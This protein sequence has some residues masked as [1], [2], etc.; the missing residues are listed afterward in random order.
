MNV[1]DIRAIGL[2]EGKD[3]II[4]NKSDEPWSTEEIDQF[5]RALEDADLNCNVLL[6]NSDKEVKEVE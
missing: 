4:C 5:S 6:C 2:E 1:E 3:Y